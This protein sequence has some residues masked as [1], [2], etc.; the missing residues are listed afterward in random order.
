MK[1]HL[2]EENQRIK[3][4]QGARKFYHKAWEDCTPME[5]T[6]ILARLSDEK[7][8]ELGTVIFMSVMALV[9]LIC[10]LTIVYNQKKKK[11]LYQRLENEILKD[12]EFYSE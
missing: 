3:Q 4:E 5:Q 8:K 6:A 10:C 12:D 7:R 9:I 1:N 2:K 11:E